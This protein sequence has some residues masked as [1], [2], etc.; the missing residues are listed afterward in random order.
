MFLPSVPVPIRD[1][2][3]N[4]SKN[5]Q[6]LKVERDDFIVRNVGGVEKSALLSSKATSRADTCRVPTQCA[7]YGPL[8]YL[9]EK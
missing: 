4:F 1:F 7:N 3:V 5:F 6:K 9:S 2:L 8:S